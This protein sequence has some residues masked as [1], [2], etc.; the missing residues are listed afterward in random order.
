MDQKLT[1]IPG[2]KDQFGHSTQHAQRCLKLKQIYHMCLILIDR[3]KQM[4]VAEGLES[5]GDHLVLKAGRVL[6]VRDFGRQALPDSNVAGFPCH[7]IAKF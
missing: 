2:Q 6:K 7:G 4:P 3:L 1:H 5:P